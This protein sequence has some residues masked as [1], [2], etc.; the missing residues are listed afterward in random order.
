MMAKKKEKIETDSSE[1]LSKKEVEEREN[2][3]LLWFFVI[4]AV[5][6]ISLFASYFGFQSMRKFE[7]SSID[8]TIEDYK[9]LRIYH[10]SFESLIRDDLIYNIYLRI[11]PRKNEVYT[12]GFFDKFRYGG[13]VSIDPEVD[14]CRGNLARAMVDLGSFLGQGIGAGALEAGFTDEA[15]ASENGKRFATCENVRDR[16]VVVVEIGEPAVIQNEENPYCYTIRVRDCDDVSAIE[17]FM[18]KSVGDFESG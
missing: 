16:T 13:I 8:W 2:V 9:D 7:Y 18:V 10:G 1:K 3:Q 11:D 6:F 5:V 17:K 15:F 12:E 14:T 4:I